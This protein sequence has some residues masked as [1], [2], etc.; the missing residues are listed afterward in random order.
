MQGTYYGSARL[1]SDMPRMVDLYMNGQLDLD[2]LITRNYHLEEINEAY[3]DLNSGG[4]G[5][6]LITRFD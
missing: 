4:I 6:G 3:D 1:Q 5:R 2:A